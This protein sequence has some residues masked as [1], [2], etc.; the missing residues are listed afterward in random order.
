[1]KKSRYIDTGS[2]I[3]P[4]AKTYWENKFRPCNKFYPR[5]LPKDPSV[6][7]QFDVTMFLRYN[8]QVIKK[9][10]RDHKLDYPQINDC[11]EACPEF[12]MRKVTYT[13]DDNQFGVPEF[14]LF[15]PETWHYRRGDCEDMNNLAMTLI[16]NCSCVTPDMLWRFR[17]CAG[18]VRQSPTAPLG[19]HLWGT[20]CRFEDDEHVK[21]D[22]CYYPDNTPIKH[23]ELVADDPHYLSVWFSYTALQAYSFDDLQPAGRLRK[24]EW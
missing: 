20:F 22:T 9:I 1:M 19:G 3:L 21:I 14:W 24:R 12:V 8:D 2:G 10:I 11:V 5:P 15:A 4:D 7:C 13:G 18:S 23:R 6:T 16:I 17:S